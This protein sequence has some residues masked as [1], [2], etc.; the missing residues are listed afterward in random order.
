MSTPPMNTSVRWP[1]DFAKRI[2]AVLSWRS[3]SRQYSHK[4]AN[5]SDIIRELVSGWVL[6]MEQEMERDE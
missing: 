2:A 3:S 5:L 1:M 4:R 6:E